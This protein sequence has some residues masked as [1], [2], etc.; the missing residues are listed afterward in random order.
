MLREACCVRREAC[1]V[2][3]EAWS[4][5]RGAWGV[6]LKFLKNNTQ[7]IPH[8]GE[9]ALRQKCELQRPVLLARV[10]LVPLWIFFH[11][12]GHEEHEVKTFYIF[13]FMSFMVVTHYSVGRVLCCNFVILTHSRS[14]MRER[15]PLAKV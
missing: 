15:Q 13:A 11:H 8:A 1:C 4:V 7:L 5:R 6:V 12:E 9:T 14:R 10:L 2:R 3:R